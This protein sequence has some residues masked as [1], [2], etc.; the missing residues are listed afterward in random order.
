[1]DKRTPVK[2]C[3]ASHTKSL[4][5]TFAVLIAFALIER[6]EM[7][8]VP[9]A[10][11]K[12]SGQSISIASDPLDILRIHSIVQAFF[13]DALAEEK[14]AS[15]WLERAVAVFCLSYDEADKRIKQDPKAGLPDDY[16]RYAVHGRKLMDHL[17]YFE[18]KA[19]YLG[20]IK[21]ELQSRLDQITGEVD[22]LTRRIATSIINGAEVPHLSIFQRTNSLS[23]ATSTETP[24]SNR[25]TRDSV[26][27]VEDDRAQFD[28]PTT[29][30]PDANPYHY[31]IPYPNE[32]VMPY[33]E[34]P[35]D[36]TVTPQ[37]PPTET[38]EPVRY[39]Y[40]DIRA[41]TVAAANHRAIKKQEEKRYRDR[42]GSWRE[43]KLK[44]S[45]PRVTIS[46]ELATGYISPVT[47]NSRG[48]RSRSTSRSRL[49]AESEAELKL[50]KIKKVSPPPPRGGGQIQDKG[51]SASAGSAPRPWPILGRPSYADSLAENAIDDE[52]PISPT[53]SNGF[54]KMPV[55]SSSYTAATI[56]RLKENSPPPSRTG[57]I[58]QGGINAALAQRSP[59]VPAYIELPPSPTRGGPRTANSSPGQPQGPFYPPGL[60]VVVNS[61]G[62]LSRQPFNPRRGETLQHPVTP[63][64]YDDE[65]DDEFLSRSFPAPQRMLGGP[66]TWHPPSLRPDGY[67]SQPMSR[68]PSSNPPPRVGS[69]ASS[70]PRL[71][72]GSAA[73]SPGV[74]PIGIFRPRR[75]SIVETE[76]SPRLAAFEIDPTSYQ[77]W[78]QRHGL[79]PSSGMPFLDGGGASGGSVLGSGARWQQPPSFIAQQSPEIGAGSSPKSGSGGSSAAAAGGGENMTR[80]GSGGIKLADGRI[81][82]FGDV[83]VDV[84]RAGQRVKEEWERITRRAGRTG[85]G[86]G[87]QARSMSAGPASSSA[88]GSPKNG[89][90]KVGLGIM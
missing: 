63:Y 81:I 44:V 46:R 83:P 80:S 26:H 77:A 52:T 43:T 17:E 6:N 42:A 3:D 8:D 66:Q 65:Y 33:E 31:H 24:E 36:R 88:A 89:T 40:Y 76:P 64:V 61:A 53:F 20:L 90:D 4:N 35:D 67:T 82:E 11:S 1:L 9:S 48:G 74:Q 55:P 62:G 15:F 34:F 69:G 12:S 18:R 14:Q 22:K 5:N 49:T 38:A 85:S 57:S 28:S 41:W 29:Y 73:G 13:I 25:S 72:S 47:G 58:D 59:P 84:Q 54:M 50:N 10:S 2:K 21:Q 32:G 39:P 60:P 71:S 70:S 19:A 87:S 86:R 30:E 78:E 56:R 7:E 37:P 27:I 23:D 51:R 16:R 68:N 75:P 79:G 45:D